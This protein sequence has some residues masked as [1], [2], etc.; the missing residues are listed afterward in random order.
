MDGRRGNDW[1]VEKTCN[2]L[3]DRRRVIIIIIIIMIC[4]PRR[5]YCIFGMWRWW[6][7]VELDEIRRKGRE[8]ET[9]DFRSRTCVQPYKYVIYTL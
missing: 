4:T 2:K 7:R 8:Y 3:S 9:V 1:W 6:R 5:C